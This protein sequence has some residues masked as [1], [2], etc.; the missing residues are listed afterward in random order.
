MSQ[1]PSYPGLPAAHQDQMLRQEAYPNAYQRS[2][3]PTGAGN[4]YLDM[5]K[6]GATVGLCGAAAANLH[7]LRNEQVTAGEAI[8][9]SLRTG[10]AAGLA[11]AAAGYV[12]NQFRS[13]TTS[14]AATLIA[15]TAFMYLLNSDGPAEAEGDES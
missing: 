13:P 8:I 7:K 14:L 1:Y 15:G 9:D 10:A 6:F 3:Y 4:S 5:G 12:A 11:T 2:A